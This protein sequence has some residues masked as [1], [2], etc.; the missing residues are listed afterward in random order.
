M[1]HTIQYLLSIAIAIGMI[2]LPLSAQ[3]TDSPS[4]YLEIAAKNN[5][6]LNAD[7][8]SYKA[9]LEKVHQVGTL[10]DPNMEIG[11]FLKPMDIVGGRQIA[12]L[13]LMQM[14]PWFGTKKTA[15][16]EATHMAKMAYEK[17]RETRDDLYLEVYT[18]WYLLSTLAEQLNN[19]RENLELLEQLEQLAMRKVS[20]PLS[21]ASSSYSLPSPTPTT[22]STATFQTSGGMAGM[23]SM[24][25]AAGSSATSSSGMSSMG[26][27]GGM[28]SGMSNAATGMS[29]V[30]RI[31]LEM[32]EIENNIESLLS[33]IES[34]KAK[35]NSLLN[36]PLTM[37]VPLPDSITKVAFLFDENV[38]IREIEKQNP[39]L[40]MLEE[41]ELAYKAKG[42][43]DKK[44][45]YPMVGIGLQYM[46][47]GESKATPMDQGMAPEMTGMDMVMP[48]VSISLP[49]Y[50][51]KYKAQ[52][53]ESRLL[54]Q[55][56]REKYNNTLNQLQSE[57]FKQKQ[58]LDNAERKIQLYQKQ[59]Q[60]ARI[61][62]QLLVQEYVS[63]KTDLTN[64]IQVQR[65]LLDYQLRQAE[66]IAEY[67]LKVASIQKL[68]SFNNTNN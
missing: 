47:I 29:D 15:Q 30:L 61:A 56:A 3:E 59:E 54:W 21:S 58:L 42:E 26:S 34:E 6:G 37:K 20:S 16:T 65:Q 12:D 64:V 40:G 13:T 32:V 45:S 2:M 7:F 23:G 10:P 66:V 35:F 57:L 49:L 8:L 4:H 18:Q 39:M 48:M 1:Q 43:M 27:T 25:S 55:S 28:S 62:Y 17:F 63:A 44:M 46:L 53:R 22:K 19:N 60:L 50:R 33:E 5:P 36:R 14:F 51:N 67:N 11:F 24:G 31:Q 68:R 38:S 9:S 52:Q 41:E